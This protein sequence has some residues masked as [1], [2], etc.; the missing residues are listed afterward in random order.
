MAADGKLDKQRI[1]DVFDAI[2]ELA[3]QQGIILDMAR[4]WWILSCFG[5]RHTRCL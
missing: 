4:L 3:S 5:I 2:G 1:E